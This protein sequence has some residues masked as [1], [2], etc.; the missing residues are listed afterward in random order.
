MERLDIVIVGHVDHGKST[1]VG[2]LLTDTDSLPEGK[3][4]QVKRNCELNSKPFEYAFLIDALKEEQAQGITIDVARVFFKSK[5]REYTIIDAPG[6]IEFLKNMITGAARAEAALLVI[7]ANEGIMENS[8][9]H[10]YLLS[11]LGVKQIVVLINKMDLVDYDEQKYNELKSEYSDFLEKIG[12]VARAFIPVSGRNGD[13]ITGKINNM[14]WYHGDDVLS[15]LDIFKK[16]EEMEGQPF[17]MPVQGVYKFTNFGDNRRIIAGTINSGRLCVD[18]EI[19]FYPSG[20]KSRVQSI[21]GFNVSKTKECVCGEACG[22][23]LNEQIFVKREE[24]ACKIGEQPPKIS[25]RFKANIFWLGQKDLVKDK[26]YYLKSGTAKIPMNIE[27]INRIIDADTLSYNESTDRVK[28]HQVAECIFKLHRAM[29]FD[30]QADIEKTS[31]F[32]IVDDYEIRGGGIIL[33]SLTDKVNDIRNS[34]ILRN[35]KWEKSSI[36]RML[37]AE[38]YNQKPSILIITGKNDV[39]K[40]TL[41]RAIEKRLFEDGK[42]VYFMGIGNVLYGVDSDIKGKQKISFTEKKEHIR[43]LSEIAYMM[44]DSGLILIITAVELDDDDLNIIK[45]V[46]SSDSAKVLWLGDEV[47]TDIEYDL[48]VREISDLDKTVEEIKSWF[49]EKGI[50]YRPY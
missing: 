29:A 12:L 48:H 7:D 41:A 21:E 45:T 4:E 17:R 9:R 23:T 22:F 24:I 26:Q 1:V 11:F 35:I 3:L 16:E 46:T 40:K 44:V 42:L 38:R 32:V 50:I 13:N 25:S 27:K 33:E 18:D 14:K 30:I 49:Q 8:R 19:I 43:R 34:V 10:G 15:A 36:S 47:S 39:G 28:R 2:R 20:K 31:R 5:V 6:H 37:R